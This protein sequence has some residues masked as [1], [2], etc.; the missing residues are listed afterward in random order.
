M[1]DSEEEQVYYNTVDKG[2]WVIQVMRTEEY[3]GV[4]RVYQGVGGPL[5]HQQGVGL[6]YDA[7]F[8]PDV[9]D[10][11]DWQELALTAIDHPE[12]RQVEEVK[13]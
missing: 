4:L 3:R 6:S 5:V 10:V 7:L 13:P 9:A 8:G 11:A 12:Q 1:T 2:T